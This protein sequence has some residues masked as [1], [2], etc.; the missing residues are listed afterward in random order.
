MGLGFRVFSP[1][2]REVSWSM[3]LVHESHRS[4]YT[5][6]RCSHRSRGLFIKSCKFILVT[7]STSDLFDLVHWPTFFLYAR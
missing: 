5:L 4:S 6:Q 2:M 3:K 1:F 7:D